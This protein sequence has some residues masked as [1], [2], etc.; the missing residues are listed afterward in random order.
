MG[1]R[2]LHIPNSIRDVV[3]EP[4]WYDHLGLLRGRLVLGS[5][6]ARNM[7]SVANANGPLKSRGADLLLRVFTQLLAEDAVNI[8]EA[9]P[10]WDADRQGI[11][12]VVVHHTSSAQ[13]M[14]LTRLNAMHLLNLYVP[15]YRNPGEDAEVIGGTP[16]YSGHAD[17]AGKQVFYGYHWLVRQDGSREHL[18]PDEAVG[19]HAGNWDVNTRSVAVCFDGDFEHG[20]PTRTAMDSAAELIAT[21][22][23]GV[24]TKRILG[25][26]AIVQTIC[27]GN[28]F[29][30][31]GE[32]LRALV[33]ANRA[34]H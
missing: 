27:P 12:T 15:K 22:Y 9:G 23:R 28:D 10:N 24:E 1:E 30:V 6:A 16:I 3:R 2:A 7:I 29:G 21:N 18:L 14:D 11:D 5:L 19:W 20:Q 8:G 25:H 34:A 32:E 13:P 26:N 31:W 4:N 33:D 17:A